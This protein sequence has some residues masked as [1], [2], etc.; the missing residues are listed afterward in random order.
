MPEP[1]H[2]LANGR[3]PPAIR[4][5]VNGNAIIS[6]FAAIMHAVPD[7]FA[8]SI[9]PPSPLPVGSWPA[10]HRIRAIRPRTCGAREQAAGATGGPLDGP[11]RARILPPAAAQQAA[12]PPSHPTSPDE[13]AAFGGSARS[14]EPSFCLTLSGE[15]SVP[16]LQPRFP[17]LVGSFLS[18]WSFWMR[19]LLAAD[20]QGRDV[21]EAEALSGVWTVR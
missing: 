10:D 6:D 16:P 14:T 5:K 21:N 15:F 7:R 20:L 8:C 13:V 4:H 1:A 9:K 12:V 3:T 2:N 11:V 17:G 18:P 19:L